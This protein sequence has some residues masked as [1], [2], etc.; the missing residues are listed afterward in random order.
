[1]AVGFVPRIFS[2]NDSLPTCA[3]CDPAT[4]LAIDRWAVSTEKAGW[5]AASWVGLLGLA[6]GTL[7]ELNGLPN[8]NADVAASFEAAAWNVGVNQLAKAVFNRN[9]PVLYSEDAIHVQA[10]VDSHRSM[11]SGHTSVSFTLGTSYYLSMS[12]KT[13]LDRSWPLISAAVIGAMRLAAGK[14]FPT[15]VLVGAV[16]GITTSII[17]HEVRF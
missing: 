6:A 9:R 14:H 3:P 12:D 11:Y 15:D 10:S 13:G 7:Y 5:G 8:G 16:L 2:I 4:L 17:V 1:M